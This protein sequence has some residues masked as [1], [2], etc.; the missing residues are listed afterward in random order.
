MLDVLEDIRKALEVGAIQSALAL[1]LTLPSV[2]GQISHP[3]ITG[4][5][6]ELKQYKA[7]Y[8]ENVKTEKSF[9]DGL[10]CYKL[11]CAYLHSGNTEL[12]QRE[13]DELPIF[14]LKVGSS[15]DLVVGDLD[16]KNG[17]V[18]IDAK[19]L[20]YR[21]CDAVQEFYEKSEDKEAFASHNYHIVDC[22]KE[23]AK[24]LEA[25]KIYMERKLKKKNPKSRDELSEDAKRLQQKINAVGNSYESIKKYG[26]TLE[27]MV[28][29]FELAEVNS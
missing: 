9:V 3:T 13:Q 10:L 2:C 16:T 24:I 6:K 23:N 12:N 28:A 17:L 21:I 5:G 11:R 26:H 29:F 18:S 15:V 19:E 20:C 27:E 4:K 22:E 14:E 7:W 1:T 8:E 25:H